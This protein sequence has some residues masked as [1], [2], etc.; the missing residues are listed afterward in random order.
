MLHRYFKVQSEGFALCSIQRVDS[1]TKD[2][3]S[4]KE[5]FIYQKQTNPR[6][7]AIFHV[8]FRNSKQ[9]EDMIQMIL[10]DLSFL[11]RALNS[12]CPYTERA[13]SIHRSLTNGE[14]PL[15]WL[16]DSPII[17]NDVSLDSLIIMLSQKLLHF[18]NIIET[19]A[20]APVDLE[21]KMFS[22]PFEILNAVKLQHTIET[23]NHQ[24][25]LTDQWIAQ[26][27]AEGDIVTPVKRERLCLSRFHLKN[28]NLLKTIPGCEDTKLAFPML[29]FRKFD[30]TSTESSKL[31]MIQVFHDISRKQLFTLAIPDQEYK[32]SQFGQDCLLLLS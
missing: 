16:E 29:P 5:K 3:S 26:V 13:Y 19:P 2:F 4:M 12:C 23:G 27:I 31:V 21:L 24:L 6:R 28:V 30:D 14:I 7:T 20:N 11:K 18:N 8:V 1:I 25:H 9:C 15:R 17:Y 10:H 22:D 32:R